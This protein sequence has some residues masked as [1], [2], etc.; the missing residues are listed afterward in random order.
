M[1]ADDFRDA[2]EALGWTEL[3]HEVLGV[4]LPRMA[5]SGPGGA[6]VRIEGQVIL[7]DGVAHV[8]G[9]AVLC[10]FP[11]GPAKNGILR[12][13]EEALEWAKGIG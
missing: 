4:R 3:G 8:D 2:V 12:S 9:G 7:G 10:K 13:Y 5:Y 6:E 1:N 11:V